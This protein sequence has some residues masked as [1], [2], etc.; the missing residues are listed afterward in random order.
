M[1]DQLRLLERSSAPDE[2]IGDFIEKWHINDRLEPKLRSSAANLLADTCA[3]FG[4][5]D[6]LDDGWFFRP[7]SSDAI[8]SDAASKDGEPQARFIEQAYRR[9]FNHGFANC[10]GFIADETLS[11]KTKSS[12]A[13][14]EKA[15]HRWRVR[16][17]QRYETPPGDTERPTRKL[18]GSRAS[19]S[20]RLRWQVFRRD[21]FRCVACGATPNE[22]ARLEAD[23]IHPFSKG[24]NDTMETLRTLCQ[25]C[26][27]GK[28]DSI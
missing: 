14:R 12:I 11:S 1:N 28:A 2:I 10:C 26:N 18:F 6:V 8:G 4:F 20:A 3:K 15:L 9:G 13:R 7:H 16:R 22:G 24:G 21:S 23:H 19:L 17:I 25:R 5:N 27:T